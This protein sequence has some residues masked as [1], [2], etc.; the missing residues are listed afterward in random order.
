SSPNYGPYPI[1]QHGLFPHRFRLPSIVFSFLYG[2]L[3]VSIFIMVALFTYWWG[4]FER[5]DNQ[6]RFKPAPIVECVFILGEIC[7]FFALGILCTKQ[8]N[9]LVKVR[10]A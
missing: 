7:V 10:E 2:F 8:R 1:S 4:G 6:E 5:G 3:W 9:L